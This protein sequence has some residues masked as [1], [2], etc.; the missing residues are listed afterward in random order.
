MKHAYLSLLFF[1]L[2]LSSFAQNDDSPYVYKTFKDTRL[3]NSQSVETEEKGVLKFII[4]H[5]FGTLDLGAKEFWGLDIANIRIGLDYGITDRL[6]VGLG[7]SNV[8]Q[9]PLDGYIKYKLL[10]QQQGVMPI[11]LTLYASAGTNLDQ[12]EASF[13]AKSFFTFHPI[14]ARKFSDRLSL[15]LSPSLI[16]RNNATLEGNKNSLIALGAGGKYQITK[17]LAI[18]GEYF[19]AFPDQLEDGYEDAVGLGLEIETNNHIFQLN[20]TNSVGMTEKV[21]ITDTGDNFF[22]GKIRFGFNI[23]RK[24]R[25]GGRNY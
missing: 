1:L 5:R 11:S 10:L 2:Y 9:K 4:S 22:D 13:K 14:I 7:R 23:T 8:I 20:F 3:I 16:L 19:F 15:Q 6:M 18:I 24:F 25:V 17:T 12:E 21:F